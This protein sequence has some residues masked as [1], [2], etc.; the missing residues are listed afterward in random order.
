MYWDTQWLFYPCGWWYPH[1]L[2]SFHQS[3]WKPAGCKGMHSFF[4]VDNAVMCIHNTGCGHWFNTLNGGPM[5]ASVG[6]CGIYLCMWLQKVNIIYRNNAEC[7]LGKIAFLS[8]ER[9]CK[10]LLWVSAD[11]TAPNLFRTVTSSVV[12]PWQRMRS[13]KG[14]CN[15]T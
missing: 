15:G 10:N 1:T 14:R 7:I 6:I 4:Y 3:R 9:S 13:V 12:P 11:A 8:A 5:V 2:R